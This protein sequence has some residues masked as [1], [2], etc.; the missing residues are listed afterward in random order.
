M[1]NPGT[2]EDPLTATRMQSVDVEIF[3]DPD[4]PSCLLLP[5]GGGE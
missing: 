5:A 2:G 1:R 3:H 4:H